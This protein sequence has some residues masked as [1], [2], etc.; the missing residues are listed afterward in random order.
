MA[1]LFLY[2]LLNPVLFC[3]VL[4]FSKL[5]ISLAIQHPSKLPVC[6]DSQNR[7]EAGPTPG[8]AEQLPLPLTG[9]PS[10]ETNQVQALPPALI[11]AS[12]AHACCRQVT[13]PS[14]WQ[15]Q[16][17]NQWWLRRR[18]ACRA[19]T[20]WDHP[21]AGV[22]R[23]AQPPS[24]PWLLRAAAP[25]SAASNFI[26]TS[27]LIAFQTIPSHGV[28]F[29]IDFIVAFQLFHPCHFGISVTH[30]LMKRFLKKKHCNSGLPWRSSGSEPALQCRE[31]GFDSWLGN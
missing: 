23:D 30:E 11:S 21:I 5:F 17:Q 8:R 1:A 6:R 25:G 19:C 31:C 15:Q 3:F 29:C 12:R 9:H 18:P 13:A 14:Q 20:S 7:W 22:T 24:L 10:V 26:S 16:S 4:D 2:W 27:Y 28:L